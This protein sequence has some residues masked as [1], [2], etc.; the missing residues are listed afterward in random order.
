M[1]IRWL[2]PFLLTFLLWCFLAGVWLHDWRVIAGSL[3]AFVGVVMVEEFDQ[4]EEGRV[5]D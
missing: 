2:V 4:I 3:I 1:T 5:H